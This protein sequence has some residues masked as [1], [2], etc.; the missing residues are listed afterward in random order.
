MESEFAE[1]DAMKSILLALEP[2]DE[3]SRTRVLRWA[4]D[5]F[6]VSP[7]AI[8]PRT[9]MQDGDRET[10]FSQPATNQFESAAELL[11]SSGA[12][13][14][15]EKALVIGYWFQVVLNQSDIESQAINTELKHIGYGVGNITRA[16]DSLVSTR[17]QLVIQLRKAGSS[18]QARKKFKLTAE[19]IRR[20][21]EMLSA[22]EGA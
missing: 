1:I 22:P 9:L 11:A 19:G 16:L 6:G 12:E 10:Q 14:D 21:N 18:K 2:L 15:T 4:G 13:T 3:T 17:P 5:K 7:S 8:K 20:V